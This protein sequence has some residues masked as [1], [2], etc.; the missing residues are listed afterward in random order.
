M[1]IGNRRGDLDILH[2]ILASLEKGQ[3]TTNLRYIAN[4]NHPQFQRY[5][6]FLKRTHCV[7]VEMR[8]RRI[9][10]IRRTPKGTRILRRVNEL[11][12]DLLSEDER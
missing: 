12:E 3:G 4:L 9:H 6:L 2:E 10:L 11:L 8:G 1:I 7:E 5:I